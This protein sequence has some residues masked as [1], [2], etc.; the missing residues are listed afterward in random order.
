ML[1]T[2]LK[3]LEL[4]DKYILTVINDTFICKFSYK[5]VKNRMDL[6]LAPNTFKVWRKIEKGMF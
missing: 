4:L 3:V 5:V 2:K 6:K 1:S